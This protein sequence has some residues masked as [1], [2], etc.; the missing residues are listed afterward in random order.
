VILID[1]DSFSGSH[2]AGAAEYVV[3]WAESRM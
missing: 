2:S 3:R 1:Q